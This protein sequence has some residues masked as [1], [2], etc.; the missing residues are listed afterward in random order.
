MQKQITEWTGQLPELSEEKRNDQVQ[1]IAEM[2]QV[3][4]DLLAGIKAM[5]TMQAK[6]G[7]K[8]V[9]TGT[10]DP[11]KYITPTALS[12]EAKTG[13]MLT[14]KLRYKQPEGTKSVLMQQS[15][16]DKG[17]RFA[18]ADREFQVAAM[19][20]QFGMQLRGSKHAGNY[21]LAGVAET[22]APLVKQ[23]DKHGHRAELLTLVKK[24]ATMK[25]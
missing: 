24:A 5:E 21:S 9:K 4:G 16:T 10:V 1:V 12:T 17:V 23:Y 25:K 3:R 2:V 22:L 6:A 15:L 14:L 19:V 8:P 13:E 11:L 18:Q 20:A 7:A